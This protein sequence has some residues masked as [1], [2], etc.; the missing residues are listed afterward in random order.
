MGLLNSCWMNQLINI[1]LKNYLG[2]C[3]SAKVCMISSKMLLW[4]ASFNIP[5]KFLTWEGSPGGLTREDDW[6]K[7]LSL[8]CENLDVSCFGLFVNSLDFRS[9]LDIFYSFVISLPSIILCLYECYTSAISLSSL[10]IPQGT[11]TWTILGS[12]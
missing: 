9:S 4:K 6:K 2:I 11:L 10:F 8:C 1:S 5:V 3:G 12:I 7:E